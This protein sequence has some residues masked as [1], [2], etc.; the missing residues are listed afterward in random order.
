MRAWRGKGKRGVCGD[1]IREMKNP[2]G[3]EGRRG[4]GRMRER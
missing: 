1:L 4:V 3:K 2:V